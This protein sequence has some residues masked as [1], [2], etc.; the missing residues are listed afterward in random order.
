MLKIN[1]SEQGVFSTA[2]N[3]SQTDE[4]ALM[5]TNSPKISDIL[6]KTVRLSQFIFLLNPNPYIFTWLAT[7]NIYRTI[8]T[9]AAHLD[10][11]DIN[12]NKNA[13]SLREVV[14]IKTSFVLFFVLST[15]ITFMALVLHIS[16]SILFAQA[17]IK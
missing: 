1:F 7:C 15:T 6:S 3:C 4:S 9:S 16:K 5:L 8:L 12:N 11:L 13:Q 2:S 17:K 14:N 10:H